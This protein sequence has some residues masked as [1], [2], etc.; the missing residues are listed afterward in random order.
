MSA[1]ATKLIGILALVAAT[2]AACGGDSVDP[3][4]ELSNVTAASVENETPTTEGVSDS[5]DVESSGEPVV[6]HNPVPAEIGLGTVHEDD[7]SGVSPTVCFWVEVPEGLQS[8]SFH[9]DGLSSDLNLEVGYGF[10][11]TLLFNTGEYWASR[12]VDAESEAIEIAVPSAGPY[13]IKIGPGGFGLTSAFSLLVTTEPATTAGPTAGALPSPDE[14]GGPVTELTI[15][16]SGTGEIVDERADPLPR[17]YYCVEAPAGLDSLTIE[18]AGLT[19][20]LDL[21]VTR[22]G[23]TE[24]W[25]DRR[26][27]GE[28]RTVTIDSPEATA[29]YIDVAAAVSGAKSSFTVSAFE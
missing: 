18:V 3:S 7:N 14:C 6:C 23:T 27:D 11:R 15:G 28:T 26:R 24:V 17:S 9:L 19:G 29:Y 2:A 20:F 16:G 12:N 5:E 25:T 13:F 4:D 1:G 10:A 22:V 8:L 21:F